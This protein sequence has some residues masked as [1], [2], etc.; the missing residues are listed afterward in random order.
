MINGDLGSRRRPRNPRYGAKGGVP[1]A[2]R[3]V[4]LGPLSNDGKRSQNRLTLAIAV[5]SVVGTMV[6]VYVGGRITLNAQ[7]DQFEEQ[8]AAESRAKRAEVYEEFLR[9]ANRYA[10][11]SYSFDESCSARVVR[12]AT[13]LLG[14]KRADLSE[15]FE[16]K[17]P[18][19]IET[20][21][22]RL[23]GRQISPSCNA[24]ELARASHT[25]Q[26][27]INEVY[28][29]GSEAAIRAEGLVSR[30]LPPSLSGLSGRLTIRPVD[31]TGFYSAYRRFQA[32]MCAE[33]PAEPRPTC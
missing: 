8:R 30:A 11:E 13:R 4:N 20:V 2:G 21:L 26:A 7:E 1:S 14:K 6:A 24:S 16:R 15:N 19:A 5:L 27:A 31:E 33:V 18:G 3:G 28:V 10:Y 29:Y 12:G 22:S 17:I 25:Y 23:F 9:R 32:V